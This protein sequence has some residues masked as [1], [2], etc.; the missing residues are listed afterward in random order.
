MSETPKNKGGRPRVDAVPITVRVPP[1][2]I[3][4]LEAFRREQLTVPTRPEAIR[5]LM[6]FA[7]R[8][9]GYL[10]KQ[11]AAQEDGEV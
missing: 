11:K 7:L 8:E 3:I 10:P 9:K 4:A 5:D 1:E 6:Q 2:L